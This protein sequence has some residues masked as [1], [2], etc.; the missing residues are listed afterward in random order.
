MRCAE[1]TSAIW[2]TGH[3]EETHSPDECARM[4]VRRRSRAA[5]AHLL[6]DEMCHNLGVGLGAELGA[7]VFQFFAQLAKVLDDAVMHNGEAVS[8]VGMGVVFGRAPMGRP[9]GMPDSDLAFEWLLG[10]PRL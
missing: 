2:H 3:S 6:R 9:A 5:L 4:V 1:E 8:G 7:L 10:E